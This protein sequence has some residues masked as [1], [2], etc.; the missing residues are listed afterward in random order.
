MK[1]IKQCFFLL[2]SKIY[3]Y[4]ILVKLSR[5]KYSRVF[6]FDIDNTIA[7]TWFS[8]NTTYFKNNHDRLLSLPIFTKMRRLISILYKNPNTIV[9]FLTARSLHDYPVTY[10]WLKS[11]GFPLKYSDLFIVNSPR[12]KIKILSALKKQKVNVYYIDDLSYN[13][14]NGVVKFYDS[15]IKDIKNLSTLQE[16]IKYFGYDDIERFNSF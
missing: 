16:N 11:Q 7:H 9:L 8:F 4:I 5:R 14:E 3:I 13:H 6:I 1:K 15:E 10:K 2:A 12:F